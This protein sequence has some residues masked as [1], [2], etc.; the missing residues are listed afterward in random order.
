MDQGHLDLNVGSAQ[1]QHSNNEKLTDSNISKCKTRVLHIQQMEIETVANTFPSCSPDTFMFLLDTQGSSALAPATRAW[2]L[3]MHAGQR[4]VSRDAGDHAWPWKV[5]IVLQCLTLEHPEALM[6]F[7]LGKEGI[8]GVTLARSHPSASLG[9]E[10]HEVVWEMKDFSC[11]IYIRCCGE[12][13]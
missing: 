7:L 13:A 1:C 9:G 10:W 8:L 11:G 6:L 5:C 4:G 2:K 3:G 12:N